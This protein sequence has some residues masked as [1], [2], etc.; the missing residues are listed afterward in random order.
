MAERSPALGEIL[1]NSPP[2]E[3]SGGPQRSTRGWLILLA[4]VGLLCLLAWTGSQ[5]GS[6]NYASFLGPALMGGA[7]PLVVVLITRGDEQPAWRLESARRH[8]E[9][10]GLCLL[11]ALGCN[12]AIWPILDLVQPSRSQNY[13][14]VAGVYAATYTLVPMLLLALGVWRWP[15]LQ[16]RAGRFR[17]VAVAVVALAWAALV[18][19]AMDYKLPSNLSSPQIGVSFLKTFVFAASEELVFRVILLS[20]LSSLLRSPVGALAISS[21][22]FGMIH[23]PFA[24]QARPD[25]SLHLW[26]FDD[27]LTMYAIFGTSVGLFLGVLWLRTRSFLLT[28]LAHT[29]LNMFNQLEAFSEVWG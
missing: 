18:G 14:A 5:G 11:L 3:V 22:L 21:V 12:L 15:K 4:V 29:L 25:V 17:F 24:L 20:Y 13:L 1:P 27:A 8:V 9:W 7:A 16:E 6:L 19:F 23:I 26:F 28:A 2:Q 10:V